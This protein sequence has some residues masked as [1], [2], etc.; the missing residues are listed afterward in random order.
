M[1]EKN[2]NFDH[3]YYF[4][5]DQLFLCFVLLAEKYEKKVEFE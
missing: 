4:D 5:H 3:L 1:A 2:L